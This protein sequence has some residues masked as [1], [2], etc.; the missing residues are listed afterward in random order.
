MGIEV[1]EGLFSLDALL[2]ADSAFLCGTAA[3]VI[4]LQSVD[5]YNFPLMWEESLGHQLQRAYKA[6]V[7]GNEVVANR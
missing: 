3:E 1:K 6:W 5:A 2:S 7:T 4:G